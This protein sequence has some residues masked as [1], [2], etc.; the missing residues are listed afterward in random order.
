MD[1]RREKEGMIILSHF[2]KIYVTHN[3]K[4][5][6]GSEKRKGGSGYS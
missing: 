1:Q 4:V 6:N 3:P 2:D 5:W